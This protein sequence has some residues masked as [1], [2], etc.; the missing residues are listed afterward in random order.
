MSPYSPNHSGR[1]PCSG[2]AAAATVVRV[3]LFALLLWAPTAAGAEPAAEEAAPQ[4]QDQAPEAEDRSVIARAGDTEPA[5]PADQGDGVLSAEP[6]ETVN[7][8]VGGDGRAV[9]ETSIRSWFADLGHRDA[10]V[11]DA[12]RVKLMGMGR[13]NLERFRKIVEESRPL[14]P[15]QA[16]ALREIV[17]HVYLSGEE[18]DSS[19]RRGFLGVTFATVTIRTEDAG[20]EAVIGLRRPEGVVILTRLPGF[21]G[22]RV[23]FDGD[24]VLNIAERPVAA[25]D[26]DAF[27]DIIGQFTAGETVRLEVLRQGQVVRVPVTLDSRPDDAAQ[28]LI[29]GFRNRRKDKLDSYWDASFRP[30]LEDGVG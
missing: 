27:M 4:Q 12:A 11:R 17:G 16:V 2:A 10:A 19:S 26:A 22:A 18:Y 25:L 7:A 5:K 13:Q 8:G 20:E 29:E 1:S 15:S 6:V 24:V 3:V 9:E 23:L 14:M 28:H 30:L 21:A